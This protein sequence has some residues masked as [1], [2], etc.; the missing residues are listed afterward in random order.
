MEELPTSKQ[1]V[2]VMVDCI[3]EFLGEDALKLSYP[4]YSQG[5]WYATVVDKVAMYLFQSFQTCEDWN[6]ALDDLEGKNSLPLMTIHKSKGLEYHTVVFLALDDE[7]W[8][9]FR[10]QPEEG[11]STFL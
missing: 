6:F 1:Q 4:E 3:L 11:K 9:S 10:K 8:W 5:D 7:A 2:R